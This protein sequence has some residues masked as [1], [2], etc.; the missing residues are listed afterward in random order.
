MYPPVRAD[1]PIPPKGPNLSISLPQVLCSSQASNSHLLLK[2]PGSIQAYN[3]QH[4]W[5]IRTRRA[6]P[7]TLPAES[8]HLY[9]TQIKREAERFK[10]FIVPK[11]RPM[12]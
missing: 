9:S 7:P 5:G 6:R 10:R 2:A 3:G 11:N 1:T 4:I 8:A 12:E